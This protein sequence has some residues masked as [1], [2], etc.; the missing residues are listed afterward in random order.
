MLLKIL[1]FKI[2]E[3]KNNLL[4]LSLNRIK[5]ILVIQKYKKFK[6]KNGII[7][8][9]K[10]FS[11]LNK[12]IVSIKRFNKLIFLYKKKFNCVSILSDRMFFGGNKNYLTV[13]RT[14]N[15]FYILRKDFIFSYYQIY[16]TKLY[17]CNLV[18]LIVKLLSL[19]LIVNL[20]NL[21]IKLDIYVLVELHDKKDLLILKY[22]K[23]K[24]ILIGF[25]N[26]NLVNFK[27]KKKYIFN[28]IIKNI[29][30]LEK[31]IIVIE[32][33]ISPVFINRYLKIGINYFLIGEKLIKCFI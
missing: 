21:S 3:L 15:N 8:E 12:Q 11:P 25:N 18:L 7:G 22:I 33:N 29:N 17:N 14:L 4:K 6:I 30:F 13:I 24:N 1:K 5:E 23:T 10:L 16:E 9:I 27:I 28:L 19:N 32:S 26:R 2:A 31:F 20:I